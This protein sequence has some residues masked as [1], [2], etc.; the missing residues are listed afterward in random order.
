MELITIQFIQACHELAV[1]IFRPF[2]ASFS[3]DTFS[4][5]VLPFAKSLSLSGMGI[6]SRSK[7]MR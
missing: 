1:L 6:L 5:R 7:V 3:A 4:H 2:S